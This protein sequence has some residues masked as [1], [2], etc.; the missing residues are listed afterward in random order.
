MLLHVHYSIKKMLWQ[1]LT[2]N[3]AAEHLLNEAEK[4]ATT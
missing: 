3:N 4:K 1:G 2:T